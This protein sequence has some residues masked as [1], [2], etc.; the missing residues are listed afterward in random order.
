MI[1]AV[2]R[3]AMLTLLDS[4]TIKCALQAC[5]EFL[6]NLSAVNLDLNGDSNA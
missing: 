2:K 3:F 5:V 1:N 4:T 6:N